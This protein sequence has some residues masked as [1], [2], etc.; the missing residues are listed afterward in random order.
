MKLQCSV[1]G[2]EERAGGWRSAGVQRSLGG[3]RPPKGEDK[4]A[5]T[6][7]PV[8]PGGAWAGLYTKQ[9]SG[10][11]E[12]APRASAT[13]TADPH[14]CERRFL[15]LIPTSMKTAVAGPPAGPLS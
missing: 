1:L 13:P 5:A 6:T 9:G 3:A 8:P 11:A 4:G 7:D 15:R 2:K 10:G 14:H 12:P